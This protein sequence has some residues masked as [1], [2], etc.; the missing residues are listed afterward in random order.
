ML[1]EVLKGD[2]VV[3]WRR[4]EVGVG[5]AG[6]DRKQLSIA[7]KSETNMGDNTR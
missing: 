7:R 2:Y 1:L 4:K 6:K 3:K 5:E